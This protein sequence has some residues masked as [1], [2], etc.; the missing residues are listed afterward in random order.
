MSALPFT[1]D[2]LQAA[3]DDSP[4]LLYDRKEAARQLSISVRSLDYLVANRKLSFRRIGKKVL[5]PY[6]ELV[7]FSRSDHFGR[8]DVA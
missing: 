7:K 3:A 8:V 2:S 1:I 4:R 6:P 5:I